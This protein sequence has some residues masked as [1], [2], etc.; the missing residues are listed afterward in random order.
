MNQPPP[1]L[2]LD[3]VELQDFGHGEKFSASI[4]RIA[5][6]LGMRKIGCTLV[7]LEPGKR[8]WPFH[9]HY[10]LEEFFIV[11]EGEGSIRYGDDTHP[12]SRGDLIFTPPGKGT[13]HQIVNTSK[14]KL[15]YLA[16]S[17]MDSPEV[18]YYPDS[19]KVGAYY[20]GDEGFTGF[21]ANEDDGRDYWDGEI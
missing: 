5:S 19:G 21:L 13:A 20:A 14:A 2:N 9:E 1:M 15:R 18:C 3:D 6:T 10:G 11:L 4:G 17:S 16:F 8:A 12:V 7:E